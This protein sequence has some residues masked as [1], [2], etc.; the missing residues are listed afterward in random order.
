M[1]PSLHQFYVRTKDLRNSI[2]ASYPPL[3]SMNASTTGAGVMENPEMFLDPSFWLDQD[4]SATDLLENFGNPGPSTMPDAAKIRRTRMRASRACIACRSRHT[5]CDAVEPVCTRCQLEDKTCVYMKSRRG[6]S[7]RIPAST[8][9]LPLASTPAEINTPRPM[10]PRISNPSPPRP[11]S[12]LSFGI[13]REHSPLAEELAGE[14]T[15]NWVQTPSD[16]VL[17][18][19]YEYFHNCHPFVLP[20]Q[21]LQARLATDPASL[22]CL[23]PVMEYVGAVYTSG[24]NKDAFKARAHELLN[25]QNLPG[26]GFSVQAIMLFSLALHCSDEY[27]TAE[28][29]LDKAI[30]IALSLNMQCEN[31]TWQHGEYDPIL[32]ESWRRTWWT[33]YCIDA[34][35][36]AISHYST[37]RLQ[38]I[39]ADMKLPCEDVEYENGSIPDSHSM[40]DYDNREFAE[41]GLVFSSF[42]YLIDSLRIASGLLGLNL[43]LKDPGDHHIEA[44][45]AKFLNWS[46]YL[47]KSKQDML[48]KDGKVDETMFLAHVVVNCEKH[49]I[50]RPHSRLLYSSIETQ[51]KCTPPSSL[52]QTRALQRSIAL[53]TTKSLEAIETAIMMFALPSPHIKHSPIVTC[54]LAL[55]VMAQVSA[56]NHLPQIPGNKNAYEEGRARIRLGLG[57]LKV[58]MAVWGMAKRS[59]REVVGVARCLLGITAPSNSPLT[60]GGATIRA[61]EDLRNATNFEGMLGSET[62]VLID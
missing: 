55:A 11:V 57:V 2:T 21:Y 19:Y 58:Q 16:N 26:T 13:A 42:T 25:S 50:H 40:V 44:V 43:E 36:A 3:P 29:Y 18:S 56:C 47:P 38:N 15:E 12:T 5:K 17:D 30:D 39:T 31:F 62:L 20:H 7:G 49:L 32:A 23:L 45:D 8:Q 54:A 14:S 1:I 33:L 35:F 41:D 51:S 37:H 4:T 6:G 59:V 61:D 28:V 52:R 48:T 46:L 22:E 10:G 53:H 60:N 9:K 27:E 24:A 34:L